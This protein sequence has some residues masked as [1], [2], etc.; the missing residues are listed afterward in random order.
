[1]QL[2]LN[3]RKFI[4]RWE[5]LRLN[6]YQCSAGVWTIGLGSTRYSDGEPV[7]KG[8]KLNSEKEAWELFEHTLAPY[9]DAVRKGVT[10]KLNQNQ[11]NALVSFVYNVGIGAFH[12]ST[13]KKR[14]NNNQLDFVPGE[15]LRWNKANNQPVLGLTNRRISEAGLFLL[16]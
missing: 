12:A 5:G 2:D 7:A 9:E 16:L 14:L 4:Q 8:D 3:G 13:L 11:F 6:A 15:F 1:M 10:I